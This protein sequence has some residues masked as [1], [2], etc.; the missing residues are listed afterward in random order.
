MQVSF[1]LQK[2][3]DQFELDVA[4]QFSRG[5]LVVQGESGS[6]KSTILNCISGLLKPD[7][8]YVRV[9]ERTLFDAKQNINIAVQQRRIGYVFQNYALFPNMTVEKNILYGMR[10]Q[11][12]YHDK[13]KKQEMMQYVDY[14]METFGIRHLRKKYPYHISGGEKQRTA[15]ARAIVTKPDLLLLDEPFSAL[16]VKTKEIVYEEFLDLKHQ[17]QLPVILIS[18]DPREGD[19]FA[20]YRLY[21][22]HGRVCEA[23]SYSSPFVKYK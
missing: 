16:D 6:G 20:D 18:H 5:V 21:L 15:L 11:P 17:F 13:Q 7:I 8:G 4:Y 22:E 2:R 23:S 19:L 10:N 1:S 9:G 12:A 3:L 14:I